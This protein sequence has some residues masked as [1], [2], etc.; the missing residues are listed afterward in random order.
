MSYGIAGA[1]ALAVLAFSFAPIAAPA[2]LL[3]PPPVA[4]HG[5][6][7]KRPPLDV[8]WMWQY[9]PPPEGG[10]EHELI[11]DPH[12]LP[13]LAQAL[14]APQAFWGNQTDAKDKPRKTLADTAYDFL[15]IPGKVIADDNRYITVTGCVFHFCPSRGLLWTDLNSGKKGQDPLVVFAAIDWIRES[16]VTTDPDA[17][18]T[19]WI[20]PSM[21]LSPTPATPN[22]MPQPLVH[23]LVRWSKEPIA[24]TGIV[25]RITRAVLVDPDG[26]PHEFKPAEIGILDPKT[27]PKPDTTTTEEPQL[28]RSTR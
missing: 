15:A 3:G 18:Y 5:K 7:D 21:P 1:L 22:H 24:R 10:R 9:S 26:T 23:S 28:K 17:E 8:E 11:Q 16:K 19:L 12:F 25:Q 20:F 14:T 13:F 27:A 2:Q 4:M 6:K